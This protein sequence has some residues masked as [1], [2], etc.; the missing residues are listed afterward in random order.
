MEDL[1]QRPDVCVR[2]AWTTEYDS[3]S[4]ADRRRELGGEDLARLATAAYM[5][6]RGDDLSALERAHQRFV[7][8]G[9]RLRAVRCAFWLGMH[10]MLR[11]E[12]ARGTGWLGRA[13]RLIG[14]EAAETAE[15]GY[16][17]LPVVKRHEASGDWAAADAAAGQAAGIGARFAEPDLIALALH[18]QGRARIRLG[19]IEEGLA[20]LDEVML[21]VI[22]EELSPI[23]TG[24]VYCSVIDACQEVYAL[25]RAREWTAALTRW[26]E[27]QPDMVSFTGRCLVHRAEILLL[28]GAWPDALE[29]A[30][31]AS[32]RLESG[33]SESATAEAFYRQGE[34]LRLS[35]A[36]AEAEE[37]YRAANRHGRQPQPGLAL[38]RLAQSKSAAAAGAIRRALAEASEPVD[39]LALLPAGVEILLAVGEISEARQAARALSEI[40]AGQGG[41]MLDAIAAQATGAV[42]LDAGE[43]GAALVALRRGLQLWRELDAPYEAARVRLLIA[44]GCRAM[45]D[46][47]SAAL[48][49]EA[50]ADVFADLGAAPDLARARSLAQTPARTGR[51]G[52][53][54]RE[55]E[56]LRL[57]AA[58]KTNKAVAA[59]L[60]VSERTVH[61]HLSNIYA[62]LGV[63]SRTQAAGFAYAHQLF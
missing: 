6:G 25:R 22:G 29:E 37:A 24:L 15:H 23:V 10:L 34:I 41:A 52:L 14:C 26:W 20:L 13:G 51:Y 58:G 17:L 40:V 33:T 47:D 7:A 39:R 31:L 59:E 3:L 1:E 19:R 57:V 54:H 43:V 8:D 5:L 53:T 49:L 62:K 56:V 35:G 30:R 36:F 38:L 28:Q 48:E 12:T 44:L 9:Q 21:S 2:Q 60:V 27:R 32:R 45:G 11:G 55:L 50:A 46:E 42:D 4:A 18:E 16:L 63:T 61:R